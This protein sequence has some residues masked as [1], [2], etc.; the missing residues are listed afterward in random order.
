[1]Q[2]S[3]KLAKSIEI[4]KHENT[5]EIL[6]QFINAQMIPK[7][8]Y[9]ISFNYKLLTKKKKQSTNQWIHEW[10]CQTK[11]DI[12]IANSHL[13]ATQKSICR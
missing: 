5:V 13:N 9:L 1:M 3:D 7:T 2:P 10:E 8:N 6:H 12:D 11:D 4:P